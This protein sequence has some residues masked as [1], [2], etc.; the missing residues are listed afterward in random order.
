MRRKKQD[1]P[2]KHGR[3]AKYYSY[4]GS[5]I[6]KPKDPSAIV[7][8]QDPPSFNKLLEQPLA[9]IAESFAGCFS[10]GK[11]LLAAA[12]TRLAQAALKTRVFR[13]VL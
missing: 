10:V 2:K 13:C 9:V 7:R 6:I 4:E 8:L 5:Y 11:R 3:K 12:G 1:H